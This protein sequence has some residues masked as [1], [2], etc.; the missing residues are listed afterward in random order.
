ME[1]ERETTWPHPGQMDGHAGP[2]SAGPT[3]KQPRNGPTSAH[4]VYCQYENPKNTESV[5]K[6]DQTQ[7]TARCGAGGCSL[8][9]WIRFTDE[10]RRGRSH[11]LSI[12]LLPPTVFITWPLSSSVNVLILGNRNHMQ[13]VLQ[14]PEDLE[15]A[16]LLP[17]VSLATPV[18][19][20]LLSGWN[21]AMNCC[22]NKI[23]KTRPFIE[24]KSL[25]HSS[26]G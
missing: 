9:V 19:M 8:F 21:S 3:A 12:S 18:T 20:T 17:A 7:S 5:V 26:R 10:S 24:K 6:G 13:S 16:P 11:L 25:A 22:C 1:R 14:T 2:R 15:I 4:I 23:P